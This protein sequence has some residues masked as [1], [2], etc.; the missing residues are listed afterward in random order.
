MA[1][2][3]A[4]E[5]GLVVKKRV[6]KGLEYL[7]TADPDTMSGKA[8]KARE[9]TTTILAEQTFWNMLGIQF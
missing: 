8:K 5:H 2:K 1:Q 7:V 6:T 3:I 9:Y 4:M